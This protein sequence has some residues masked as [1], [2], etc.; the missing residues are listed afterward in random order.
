VGVVGVV[1]V[2]VVV[3]VVRGVIDWWGDVGGV[4]GE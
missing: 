4:A 3:V 1:V 2:V